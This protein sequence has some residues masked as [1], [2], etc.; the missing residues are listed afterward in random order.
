MARSAPNA[1]PHH[2]GQLSL[3]P[4]QPQTQRALGDQPPQLAFLAVL[5]LAVYAADFLAGLFLV[6]PADFFAAVFFA[7]VFFAAG[8]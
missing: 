1:P 7:A 8:L 4:A 5:F 2:H 3:W 6:A